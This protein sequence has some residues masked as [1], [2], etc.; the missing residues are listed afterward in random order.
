MANILGADP[1]ILRDLD[2]K[3]KGNLG[4]YQQR[5]RAEVVAVSG[6]GKK[7]RV[8][9]PGEVAPY[10]RPM[11]PVQGKVIV[12]DSVW[13]LLDNGGLIIIAVDRFVT[14]TDT[15]ITNV[16]A[17]GLND[18][19]LVN[20]KYAD[21]SQDSRSIASSAV[22]N[23][24]L[25]SSSVDSIKVALDSLV[26]TSDF[27]ARG[28]TSNEVGFSSIA[29]SEIL[30]Q[31]IFGNTDIN[32]FSIDGGRMASGSVGER[33]VADFS[34]R[35]HNIAD[36]V[37]GFGKTDGSISN[38]QHTHSSTNFIR[39]TKEQRIDMLRARKALRDLDLTNDEDLTRF[40][41]LVRENVENALK[42]HMDYLHMDAYQREEKLEKDE[43]WAKRYND[44]YKTGL[45][46]GYEP[47][48]V[49]DLE[50]QE[51]RLTNPSA[52]GSPRDQG[53]LW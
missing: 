2:S 31:G 34:L 10:I 9:L 45:W 43:E 17:G 19:S 5:L 52:P 24:E 25:A 33:I 30:D 15:S 4:T 41:H 32:D 3:V 27:Q 14:E 7:A 21:D 46:E 48:Q 20:S 38:A 22:G 42:L 40:A 49:V 18:F 1:Q 53:P 50:T 29:T 13:V 8:K 37:I 6:D 28:I 26:P 51:Q 44:H 23:S 11:Y 12:G 16:K 35:G 39:Y 47:I 36:G